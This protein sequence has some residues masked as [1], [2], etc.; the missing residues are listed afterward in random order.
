MFAFWFVN[1]YIL[2]WFMDLFYV[3]LSGAYVLLWFYPDWLRA[4]AAMLPFQAALLPA[5]R[6]L[7]RHPRRSR[8]L[9]GAR[10]SGVLDR[11]ALI[12]QEILWREERLQ[13]DCAGGWSL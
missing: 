7:P 9:C 11:S 12:L 1:V 10:H 6:D 8:L 13:A 2:N 4:I 5:G 3:L